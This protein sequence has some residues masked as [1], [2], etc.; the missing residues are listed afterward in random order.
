MAESS[1][2]QVLNTQPESEFLAAIAL[3]RAESGQR[4]ALGKTSLR[5]LHPGEIDGL[6]SNGCSASDWGSILVA[7]GFDWHRVERVRFLGDVILGR[8]AGSISLAADLE[9][10]SGIYD[11]TI[12]HAVI[13]HDALVSRVGL[14]CR[15]LV[16]QG[17][18]VWNCG[19]VLCEGT[20]SFAAGDTIQVG[21]ERNGRSIRIYPELDMGS[22]AAQAAGQQGS[23]SAGPG[24]W[25]EQYA[26]RAALPWSLIGA[27][28]LLFSLGSVRNVFIGPHAVVENTPT[29]EETAVLSSAEE[30]AVI[31]GAARVAHSI[32]QWGCRVDEA[33]SVEKSVL[34][35]HSHVEPHGS[36]SSCVL[37]PN[38][39]IGKGEAGFSLIGP[40]VNLHHQAML[41]GTVWPEGKG[42]I[43]A[44]AHVGANHTGRAPDQEFWPGEGMFIGMGVNVRFPA[45]F[46]RAPFSIVAC[47]VTT[48][49]QHVEFPFSLIN[50]PTRRF[51]DV[52]NHFNQIVPAWVLTDSLYTLR[53]NELK[54]QRRNKARRYPIETRVLRP[55]VFGLMNEACQRLEQ[56]NRNKPA[57]TEKDIP[58]L[59]K[60][61]MT[62]ES[63]I[64][65]LRGYR[66]FLRLDALK[67]LRDQLKR[68]LSA[69]SQAGNTVLQAPGADPVW[70]FQRRWLVE[71]ERVTDAAAALADLRHLLEYFAHE[72][73]RS[74]AKDD[75]RGL[76]IREDY[77][78]VHVP[79]A[80]DPVVQETWSEI[81]CEL[82][83]IDDMRR[84]LGAH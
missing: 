10:P 17:A 72:V 42:N 23:S 73:E 62:E 77:A 14:I 84:Q 40:F 26:S 50:S 71:Q 2:P 83:E 11:A 34:L 57:Y 55:E 25:L 44:G 1:T 30:P 69:G 36:L 24:D 68:R 20:T 46:T 58:G 76:Q 31:A 82:A 4:F 43:S 37:G 52:P 21:P 38:S 41:I 3:A 78:R 9:H 22:A 54:F 7:D 70:E 32:V 27:G 13:G 18:V 61:Y 47:S 66:W 33:A 53:R 19:R 75:E 81:R 48:S 8:F 16:G 59:G 49:P 39:V 80:Q 28:A 35:E 60:N 5:P 15:A 6:K 29:I 63:R 67:G 64:A 12:A 65:A 79:A 45:D 51:P 56:V 74:K